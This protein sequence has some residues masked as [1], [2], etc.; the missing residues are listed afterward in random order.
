MPE[1]T[2]YIDVQVW[3]GGC[4]AGLCGQSSTNGTEITV[5]PCEICLEGA[6][7]K[8]YDEGYDAATADIKSGEPPRGGTT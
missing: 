8:G 2:A 6:E 4:N 3:C 5:E 1:I 7:G